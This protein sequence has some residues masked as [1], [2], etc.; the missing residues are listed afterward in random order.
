MVLA[1][2]GKYAA[3]ALRTVSDEAE[4]LDLKRFETPI[5]VRNTRPED[6]DAVIALQQKSFPGMRPW[7]KE[8]IGSHLQHFPEGQFVVELEGEVIGSCSSL[9]LDFEEYEDHQSFREITENGT[10]A[11][12]DPEGRNLYGIEVMVDPEYRGMK[13]GK[14][15]YEARKELCERLNLESIVIAGRMPGY[16]KVADRMT[17]RQYVEA[18]KSGELRDPVLTFQ[19]AQGFTVKRL[20]TDYLP[21]D[22]ESRGNAVLLEWSNLEFRPEGRRHLKSS[23]PVRVSVIQYKMRKVGSFEEFARQTEYFVDVAANYRSDFAVFPELITTQLL[24]SLHAKDPATSMQKLASYT[25]DYIEHFTN[26]AVSYNLHIL[27]GTHIIEEDGRLYNVAF[28]FKRDGTIEKQ[29]KL[30]ITLNE[31]RWWGIAPGRD[32]NIIETDLGKVAITIC[33]DIEF[34]E[35]ARIA[36]DRGARILFVPF[37]TEDRQGYLRVRYCAQAR[38]VENQVYVVTAGT[39]GNLPESANMDIQYAQSAIYTPSDF[40][41]PRDGIQAET[42]PNVEMVIVGDVDLEVLRRHRKQGSVAQLQDRRHDLYKV[43]AVEP[44][45]KDA[46]PG[47]KARQ[48]A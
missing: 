8:E 36:T 4:R 25:D 47:E 27:G 24:S 1:A 2:N 19:M 16:G 7:R 11:N 15:L 43:V 31:R 14:R 39:V 22:E 18:V 30:H 13:I 41:F 12:H 48:D 38:A 45:G 26:L 35:V 34:P 9:I 44:Q 46:A 29:Y 3:R 33:Y 42:S 6:F 10:I 21:R 40:P 37:C 5:H 28:L 17:P 20:I 23:L 32:I